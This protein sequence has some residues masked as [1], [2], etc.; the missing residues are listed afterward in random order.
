MGS[1]SYFEQKHTRLRK[2][3]P[4]PPSRK[5][6]SGAASAAEPEPA[7]ASP[8]SEGVVSGAGGVALNPYLPCDDTDTTTKDGLVRGWW[9][10][11]P[12]PQEEA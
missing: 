9:C 8:P 3:A 1:N 12:S 4:C 5:S 6:A 2:R 11:P 10:T 7:D